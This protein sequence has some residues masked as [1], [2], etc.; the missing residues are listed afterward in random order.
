MWTI[1]NGRLD[2][3][4]NKTVSVPSGLVDMEHDEG[5]T[6]QDERKL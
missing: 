3:A 5:E 2:M 1:V 6:L 4:S